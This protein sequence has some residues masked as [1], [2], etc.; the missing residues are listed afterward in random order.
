ML[1]AAPVAH[2]AP[3]LPP[4]FFRPP[5]QL[6]RF[7]LRMCS[8]S[9]HLSDSALSGLV[10]VEQAAGSDMPVSVR[11]TDT[12]LSSGGGAAPVGPLVFP[13]QA[14]LHP[15]ILQFLLSQLGQTQQPQGQ[16]QGGPH[17]QQLAQPV[18]MSLPFM[19]PMYQAFMQV[20][21]VSL[22]AECTWSYCPGCT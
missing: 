19:P 16:S 14:S 11:M 13:G 17:G 7:G 22:H 21:H 8:L 2:P 4:A 10:L 18:P 20:G 1:H 15:G 9:H 12:L 3:A 5:P 6:G